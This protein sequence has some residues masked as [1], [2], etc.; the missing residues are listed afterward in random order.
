MFRRNRQE[1]KS[2]LHG[3]I[4][5]IGL[6]SILIF[7]QQ[8]LS[9]FFTS[10]G[11]SAKTEPDFELMAQAWE[12]IRAEYVDRDAV[13]PQKMTYGAIAGM[14]EALGDTDHST[15]LSPQMLKDEE[16]FA[17]GSYK[18]IGAEL[19]L[20][21]GH[22]VI[23]APFDGSPAQKAGL[24]PGQVILKVDGKSINGLPLIQVV[25][26]I[27][28]EGGTRVTL[29]ILSPGSGNARDVTL[30]RTTISMHNVTWQKLPGT[31][32]AHLRLAGFSEGVAKDMRAAL[33][34]ITQTGASGIVLDLRD[35]P[36]GL[37]S[38]AIGV[39]S[40]FLREG[41][42]LLEKGVTG[43]I[44]NVPVRPGGIA[45]KIP[46]VVLIN[47]GSASAAEILSGALQ[48]AG[49]AELIGEKTFGTGTVLQEF[50]LNDGSALLLAVQEW[51]TPKGRVIWHQGIDPDQKVALPEGTLP[52]FPLLERGMTPSELRQSTDRQLLA[53]LKV[54][55]EERR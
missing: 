8:A 39:A 23:V 21:N 18:G 27:S 54:L 40:L 29:T 42:V 34:E 5:G 22:V 19:R 1:R 38:E 55:K 30:T 6:M 13:K 36:G 46:L 53:A 10:L 3:L 35:N 14:V 16:N 7:G 15:F 37:L 11:I 4:F 31:D 45:P 50:P 24:R 9:A 44:T 41:N 49:R 48:D 2:F 20:K 32:L 28:G 26:R 17:K 51:L 52:L 33:E 25:Q 12:T 47:S 43:K